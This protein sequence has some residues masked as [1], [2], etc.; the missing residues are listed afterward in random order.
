MFANDNIISLHALR[1]LSSRVTLLHDLPSFLDYLFLSLVPHNVVTL[2]GLLQSQ[3]AWLENRSDTLA[4]GV[5]HGHGKGPWDDITGVVKQ[6]VVDTS[7]CLCRHCER[8][9]ANSSS[10]RLYGWASMGGHHR[11]MPMVEYASEIQSRSEYWST[12]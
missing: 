6:A 1:V 10:R 9:R 12:G 5:D 11:S 3:Y 4:S 7:S 8:I 2:P